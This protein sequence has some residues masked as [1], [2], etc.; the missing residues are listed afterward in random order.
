MS[1]FPKRIAKSLNK[2][3]VAL[4]ALIVVSIIG[5][6]VFVE[7]FPLSNF[8]LDITRAIQ[9]QRAWDPTLLM[10]FISIFGDA[11]VAP[12]PV[13]IASLIFYRTNRRREA[14]FTLAVI[15]A[16]LGNFLFKM[17]IHRPR[18]T[19]DV[20]RVLSKFTETGFPSGHV[21]HYVVFFGFL[22]TV[23]IVDK[24]IP[25]FWRIFVGVL[26]TF[27]ILTVSISRIYLGA[28]WA[29]DVIGGYLFGFACLGI[30]L[31]YYLR[32]PKF[33]RPQTD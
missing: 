28:H 19:L 3:L 12:F 11:A 17:L 21:V 30:I 33:K 20:A 6:T 16:N 2:R 18:P 32:D 10:R 25:F 13:V 27:L 1:W 8:D 31:R 24:S 26:S 23:M 4:Y 14:R 5:L 15:L 22:L 9:E 29:T 7:K